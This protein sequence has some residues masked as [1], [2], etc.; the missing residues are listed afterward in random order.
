MSGMAREHVIQTRV[1]RSELERWRTEAEALGL[2][3]SAWVRMQI[4]VLLASRDGRKRA[5]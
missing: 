2:T 5:A 1:S 3:V 4:A